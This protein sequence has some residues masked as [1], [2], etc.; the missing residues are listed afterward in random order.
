LPSRACWP[1]SLRK[2]DRSSADERWAHARRKFCELADLAAAARRRTQGKAVATISPLA[3]EAVQRIDALFAIER[4]INGLPTDQRL[5]MR[6]EQ[7]APLVSELEAWMRQE[8]ARL[9]RHAEVAKAM[10]YL[11]KRWDAFT[12]FLTNGRICLSNM[13]RNG[14]CVASPLVARPGC[15]PAPIAVASVPRSCTA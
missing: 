11:L 5:A 9:S 12:R 2:A 7:S 3:L 13:P 14:P 8:R 10:D 4:D 15:S 6:Q 1:G